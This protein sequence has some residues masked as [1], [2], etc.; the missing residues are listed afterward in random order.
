MRTMD[1]LLLPEDRFANRFGYCDSYYKAP[2]RKQKTRKRKEPKCY[3][4]E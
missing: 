2:R 3:F 4:T 1:D